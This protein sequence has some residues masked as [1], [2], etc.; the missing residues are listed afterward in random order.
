MKKYIID[1]AVVYYI[2]KPS[3]EYLRKYGK[4]DAIVLSR[5]LINYTFA[6]ADILPHEGL[7]YTDTNGKISQVDIAKDCYT[8]FDLTFPKGWFWIHRNGVREI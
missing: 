8:V 5:M 7:T 4:A 2:D 6:D 1:K 3:D